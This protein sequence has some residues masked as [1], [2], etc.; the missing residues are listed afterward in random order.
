MTTFSI[1]ARAALM[2]AV[3]LGAAAMVARPAAADQPAPD[4]PTAHF[5][6]HMLEHMIDHHA[7]GLDMARMCAAKATMAELRAMCERMVTVGPSDMAMLQSWLQSWYGVTKQPMVMPSHMQMMARMQ[8]LS[9][10]AFE[11]ELM[12][13]MILHHL[14]GTMM[15]SMVA[16]HAYHDE[17]MNH[18]EMMIA[19]GGNDLSNMRTLLCERHG[20]CHTSGARRMGR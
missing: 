6:M 14:D 18:A 20:M 5:E 10:A 4:R 8:A 16:M 1:P 12:E 19:E 13:E 7:M 17:F 3:V 15:A 9:G 11:V 2:L